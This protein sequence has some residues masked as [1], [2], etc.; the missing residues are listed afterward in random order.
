MYTSGYT[1][2]T[3][4][5]RGPRFLGK[6]QSSKLQPL[7]TKPR[8]KSARADT[9]R[10]RIHKSPRAGTFLTGPCRGDCYTELLRILLLGTSMNRPSADAS[11]STRWHHVI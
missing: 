11:G 6:F 3:E 7:D 8:N 2:S 4:S 10:T 5:R 9:F 1:P